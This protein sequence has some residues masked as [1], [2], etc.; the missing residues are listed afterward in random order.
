MKLLF[1]PAKSKTEIDFNDVKLEGKIGVV[2][3]IQYLDS[4]KKSCKK[5]NFF[6]G[7]ILG[8]NFSNATKIKKNVDK[9]LYVGTGKFHS[10]ALALNTR[11]D[12]Y[13]LNPITKKFFKLDKEDISKYTKKR[14][15]L[16][17]RFLNAKKIGIL[18][19]LKSGQYHPGKYLDL[20]NKL[21]QA[22]KIKKLFPEKKFYIFTF[23]T[24]SKEEL[25]NFNDIQC[26]VNLACP[27]IIDDSDKIINVEE[28]LRSVK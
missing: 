12:V 27:R 1:I 26:W 19:T 22:E 9:F 20:K 25:D 10:L 24:L 23:N 18:V 8:C 4:V 6:F 14:K 11:K 7:Q 5:N 16:L 21:K 28:I 15:G 17:L 2:T 3:T 13:I